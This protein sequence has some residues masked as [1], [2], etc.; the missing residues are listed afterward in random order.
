MKISCKLPLMR[1]AAGVSML[2]LVACDSATLDSLSNTANADSPAAGDAPATANI[3]DTA[4]AAGSFNT[5]VAALQATELDS[6]LADAGETFTV[7]APTDA[8]FAELGQDTINSLLNDPETLSN[9]LLYHVVAGSAVNA[10]TAI[11]LA[12]QTVDAANGDA[13]ALSLN[14]GAL[15]INESEVTATDIN[16][17]NGVIHVIDRV[18]LPPTDSQVA[19]IVDTAIGAGNFTT[20]V[21]AL[22][23][24]GLD[25]VL[26]DPGSTFTVFAPTDEAFNLLGSATID[27]LLA[28][29]DTLR[30]ILLYH[31]LDGN[32]VDSATAISLAGSSV[33]AANGDPLALSLQG[34]ALFI[35]ESEV[36][37]TDIGASNGVI[38]V[39]DAVLIPPTDDGTDTGGGSEPVLA[40]IVDTAVAAGSFNTLAAALAATGLDSVLADEGERFTVFAPTDEAFAA[41]GQDT[42]NAL[43]GDPET[44]SDI[45]LYHVISGT[46]INAETAIGIAGTKVTTANGD[47]FA[48]SLN[49]GRLFVNL[50]EVISTDINASNGVIH[51]ID[52]V[53]LPPEIVETHGSVVD[54]AVADGRFTTLV[55][56]LQ[57]TG[58]DT[59]LADHAGIFTVFAPTDAAFAAL[60]EGVVDSLLGDLDTLSQILLTHVITDASIDSVTAFSLSGGSA[61]TASG[62]SVTLAIR[63]GSLFINNARVIQTDIKAENG[64]IHV[65]DAVID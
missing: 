8:A 31:V 49:E 62:A 54:L 27:G 65:L 17:T 38:H 58:L 48:L 50:S 44:L 55:A 3:V 6:V 56:A 1:L 4:V 20:L 18:L 39:I 41:L 9:I 26:A 47:E 45:L 53:L 30:D 61:V 25:S 59:V 5:L 19:N 12:G 24:T 14:D 63:D 51:V 37:A 22:Q 10:E 13:L 23:A 7:F 15:F 32:A 21:A 36:T 2:A 40:N 11:S 33:D 64:I 29:P 46:S 43:L 35:N 60:G 52:T 42:I 16:A 28:D 34:G 57:A